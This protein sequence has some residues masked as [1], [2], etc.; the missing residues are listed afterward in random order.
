[1]RAEVNRIR[2]RER[3]RAR[4]A[5][6]CRGCG[7][8]KPRGRRIVYCEACVR[9]RHAA[10]KCLRCPNTTSSKYAKLCD[11][12]RI[13]AKKARRLYIRQWNRAN[14]KR[15]SSGTPNPETRRLRKALQA[16]RTGAL[17]VPIERA[18]SSRPDSRA[19]PNLPAAP[20]AAM[21]NKL[22]D[23]QRQLD[24]LVIAKSDPHDTSR[25]VVCE[26][27]GINP[28]SLFAWEKGERA[29]VQFDLA[30]RTIT[31][32][33]LMWFDVYGDDPIAR[34]A[35]TGEKVAA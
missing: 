6:P 15:Y 10:R 14:R 17:V 8:P 4:Y 22:I 12:C 20:L 26:R 34:Q 33:G 16:E 21:V 25:L 11:T 19:F 2:K 1:L 5:K 31:R 9:K 3:E 7:R 35:F 24:P 27:L 23:R 30:D 32:A 28:R 18:S 29:S 13:A